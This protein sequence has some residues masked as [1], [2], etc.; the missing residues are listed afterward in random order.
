M[1]KG[2]NYQNPEKLE[3]YLNNKIAVSVDCVIFGYDEKSL[4]VLL[5]KCDMPEFQNQHSLIGDLVHQ[6][7]KLDAAAKRVLNATVND[8]NI[9]LEEVCTFGD[10][11]R[12]PLGRVITVAYYALVH[13]PSFEIKQTTGKH[14]DWVPVDQVEALAFDHYQ[15]LQT[16]MNL[17]RQRLQDRPIGF[18][19]LPKKFTLAQLQNLYEMVLNL[20]MDKR[21]FRRKIRSL[22]ILE[23]L[24]ESETSVS[25]RPA[26][27]YKFD[28]EAYKQK[29]QKGLVFNI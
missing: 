10:V 13:I 4:K 22:G 25:H 15:I 21:N 14:L 29:R 7:E 11:N 1:I 12:H 16:S 20:E 8:S 17:L 26:K 6:E 23:D 5:M 27:L 9:Y 18:N 3:E 2:N 28:L 24:E 19:L